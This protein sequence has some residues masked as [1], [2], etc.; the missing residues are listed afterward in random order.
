MN[1]EPLDRLSRLA[2][3]APRYDDIWGKTHVASRST[4]VALLQAMDILGDESSMA[5]AV[6]RRLAQTWRQIA[7]PVAVFREEAAPYRLILHYPEAA[8]SET[9]A[10]RLALETGETR[11]GEFQPSQL[12]QLNAGEVD[13][14][15]HI[16]VA[17]HW[18]DRL[19]LGYHRFVVQPRDDAAAARMS[20][21]A[22]ATSLIITPPRCYLPP[23]LR[24]NGRTWGAA[25]QL[26]G[27]RST[28]NWG[29]GDYTDLAVLV[30]QWARRGA[31]VIGVN[32][33]HAL[34][35]H[36]PAH[37][38]PYSPS[39]RRFLNVL[40][41]DVEAVDDF[42]ECEEA[43]AQVRS[44]EFQSRLKT[45]RTSELVDYPAVAALKFPVL[46]R[47]YAHFRTHHLLA[48]SAR[49][50][51]FRAFQSAGGAALRQHALFE[52]L[53]QRFHESDAGIWGFPGWP[54]P[55][56]D[57]RS[58]EVA[59]YA[60]THV[61]RVEFY[62][63]LQWQADRQLAAAAERAR[64]TGMEVGL[65]ADVAV[66]IDAAGAEAWANQDC[67]VL[68]ATLG[69]PPDEINLKGQNWGLPPLHPER[70]R[71]AAYAPFIELLRANMRHAGAVRIDHV[72]GLARLFWIPRGRD[73]ADGT[74]VAFPFEDLLG[75]L[76]LESHRNRC[77]V[78]G[79]DLGTVPDE[80]RAGLERT[81]VLS[82][83]LLFFERAADGH[84]KAPAEYPVDALVA[85]ST[86][87]LPTLTGYWEGYDLQVRQAL[88]LFP[89]EAVREAQIVGRV[90]DRTRLVFALEREQLRSDG[91]NAVT[92]QPLDAG[93]LRAIQLYLA[94]SPA[95]VLVVQ[96]ED[97]LGVREQSN[98]PG[99]TEEH[100]NWRRKLPLELERFP[101]DPRFVALAGAIAAER[102]LV[103][104]R[105]RRRPMPVATIP[106]ATYRV[107][108]HREF[109][110]ADATA[111]VPYLAD[112]GVSHVYCSPYLRAR[113]GST[114]GYDIVDHNTLNPEIGSHE[115]LE[116]F[117]AALRAR[118]MGHI[119][120]VVPNHVG[121]M[122]SDS[123]W[124]LDVLEN[125]PA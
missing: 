21:G 61:E 18:H 83:R 81:G 89:S 68:G 111:L 70:L 74:Y 14:A 76:A 31:G 102:P 32:P 11:Q 39:S 53:Q 50:R 100:P 54:V 124:W 77:L 46:E 112:L 88:G 87:D 9:M 69:A 121:V 16:Q 114:H 49:A 27:I 72:M 19:P 56:R 105:R 62:E 122:G 45:A 34:Y 60:E 37:A 86:H 103:R 117:V 66:S 24:E 64:A 65:Y 41:I 12:E 13:G 99:T 26:Y 120:D 97:V 59:R 113:P 5:E 94:R 4:Q 118:G 75:V 93:A 108:L 90:Q 23:A 15:R 101:D 73:G 116:R 57:P 123:V 1:G 20:M 29:I 44:A 52:A 36:N 110:F 2:G 78:I 67:Y 33:L 25:A 85:A 47:L 84:F 91:L 98:L 82:Y 3:V 92:P 96:L 22:A 10:W 106:R 115:D 55:Y 51:A 35:P 7:P 40:Y 95:R 63:Y 125:G 30:D 6:A 104:P 8:V 58:P 109:T 17:F 28:R 38:S 71:E 107:Q 79:E 43:R 119:L 80:V 42:R 48:D